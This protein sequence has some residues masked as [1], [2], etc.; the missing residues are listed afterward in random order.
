MSITSEMKSSNGIAKSLSRCPGS[1]S[2]ATDG[3]TSSRSSTLVSAS[4]SRSDSVSMW[5]A[6]LV[7]L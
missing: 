2:V 1:R 7:A 6:A 4:C 5:M 3:G